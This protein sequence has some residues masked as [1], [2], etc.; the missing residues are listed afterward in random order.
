MKIITTENP[1]IK[2]RETC[3]QKTGCFYFVNG[4]RDQIG[5]WR[6]TTKHLIHNQ[7]VQNL[8]NGYARG[9][10]LNEEEQKDV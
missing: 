2:R 8:T 5:F 1:D 6:V 10:R 4:N 9:R 3:P 7:P